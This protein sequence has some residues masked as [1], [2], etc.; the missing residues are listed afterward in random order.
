MKAQEQIKAAYE[1][2]AGRTITTDSYEGVVCGYHF[3]WDDGDASSLI[4]AITKEK[5]LQPGINHLTLG[6]EVIT[7]RGNPLGY[8]FIL[9]VDIESYFPQ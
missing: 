3:P 9:L 6:D 8:A 1:R 2:Y 4:V 7:H 5:S